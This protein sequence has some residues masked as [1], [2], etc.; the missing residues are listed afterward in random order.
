MK[1]REKGE[2]GGRGKKG[3]QEGGG[4]EG[5]RRKPKDRFLERSG[6]EGKTGR[7]LGKDKR[8]GCRGVGGDVAGT[9]GMGGDEE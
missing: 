3:F 7:V 4:G 6:S 1:E 9:G 2:K 5:T 8:V